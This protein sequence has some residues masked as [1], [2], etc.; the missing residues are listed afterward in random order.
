LIVTVEKDDVFPS[1][2]A[3]LSTLQEYS[4]SF[5]YPCIDRDPLAIARDS[6]EV[7]W[8]KALTRRRAGTAEAYRAWAFENLPKMAKNA[9]YVINQE[10][11]D[12]LV[13][14]TGTDLL[15]VWREAVRERP[16]RLSF[17]VAYRIV[18]TLFKMIDESESCRFDSARQFLHVPLDASTLRPLRRI[19][20]ELVDLDYAI[21]IPAA[22]PSGFV[23][24]E[25][26]YVL[27]QGALATL[28]GRAGLPPIL[29]A[30]WCERP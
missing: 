4:R 20:D 25:E 19:V 6:L 22:A 29:Y 27:L 26:Q 18:D 15:R 30:Y 11:F 24:T 12:L 5:C 9:R 2:A 1:L 23:A 3:A 8:I 10:Q 21:E 17:G 28:A 13:R 14:R 16:D 7:A